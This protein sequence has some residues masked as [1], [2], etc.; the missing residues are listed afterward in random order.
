MVVALEIRD[1]TTGRVL[2]VL[3]ANVGGGFLRAD[4]SPDGSQ[5]ALITYPDNETVKVF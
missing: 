5:I 1:L 2:R 3:H 4:R